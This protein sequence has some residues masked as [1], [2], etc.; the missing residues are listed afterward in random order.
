ME[1]SPMCWSVAG[2]TLSHRRRSLQS[3]W[4][5]SIFNWRSSISIDVSL[6]CR[7]IHIAV[8]QSFNWLVSNPSLDD[9]SIFCAFHLL[10]RR[11]CCLSRCLE[12]ILFGWLRFVSRFSLP[13]HAK[14]NSISVDAL[15][16]ILSIF[17]TERL[18]HIYLLLLLWPIS[19]LSCPC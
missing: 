1:T 7:C 2:R 19:F 3:R 8:D 5:S 11:S 15:Y 10:Q 9:W 17:T 18:S 12:W 16:R 13:I 4:S 14:R 6:C